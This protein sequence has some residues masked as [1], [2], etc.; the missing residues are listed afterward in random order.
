MV[1]A[2]PYNVNQATIQIHLG[3]VSQD[4][5]Q[6]I[7]SGMIV[8][9]DA[10]QHAGQDMCM[11]IL[12]AHVCQYVKQIIDGMVFNVNVINTVQLYAL[13]EVI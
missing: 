12:I 3:I 2:I 6:Q 10:Y 7:Q 13:Q 1:D 11:T 4:V 8:S 5:I 9:K